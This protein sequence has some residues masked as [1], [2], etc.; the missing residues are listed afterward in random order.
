MPNDPY[1]D[2][3][4]SDVVQEINRPAFDV[5]LLKPKKS[6]LQKQSFRV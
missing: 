5:D 3:M 6:A 1:D 2:N 4:T